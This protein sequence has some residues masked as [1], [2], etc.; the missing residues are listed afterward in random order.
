ME[1]WYVMRRDKLKKEKGISRAISEEA[2][3]VV[4]HNDL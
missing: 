1:I 4:E 2:I 3:Q